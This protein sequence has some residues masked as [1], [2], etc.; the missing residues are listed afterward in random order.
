M[1][2]IFC[3][4]KDTHSKPSQNCFGRWIDHSQSALYSLVT[5]MT[6]LKTRN[7]GWSR[8]TRTVSLSLMS[9]C[10]RQ[11]WA[12]V[13][14]AVVKLEVLWYRR[15]SADDCEL[16]QP[17][18]PVRDAVVKLEV[19]LYRRLSADDCEL[20]QPWAP[21]RDAVVKLEVLL[22]RRLSVDKMTRI[23]SFIPNSAPSTLVYLK[24]FYCWNNSV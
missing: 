12:P 18:A 4:R 23:T 20:S 22:Y 1:S 11:P 9:Y 7:T 16:S 14:D 8:H 19:L 15:L 21:V 5:P 17:W 13:R 24:L 10:E 6:S 2:Q 3:L